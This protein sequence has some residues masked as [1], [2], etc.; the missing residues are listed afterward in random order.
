MNRI[1]SVAL[2]LGILALASMPAMAQNAPPSAQDMQKNVPI[3]RDFD[4]SMRT[5]RDEMDQMFRDFFSKQDVTGW[6]GNFE[7]SPATDVVEED[8]DFLVKVELPGMTPDGIDLSVTGNSIVIKGEKQQENEVKGDTYLRQEMSYGSFSR[9]ISLPETADL[10]KADAVYKNG[11][12]TVTVPKN[13]A[14]AQKTR[15]LTIRQ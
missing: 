12:L 5:M 10:D 1:Q 3:H 6:G 4:Q 11:V 15:K 14:Y 2:A 7:A 9:T 13:P 8:K